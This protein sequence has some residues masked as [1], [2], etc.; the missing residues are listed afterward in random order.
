VFPPPSSLAVEHKYQHVDNLEELAA[1][2]AALMRS[3]IA[4]PDFLGALGQ[5][6]SRSE[7]NRSKLFKLFE[8]LV[9]R[10]ADKNDCVLSGLLRG[11]LSSAKDASTVLRGNSNVTRCTV[12]VLKRPTGL[13]KVVEEWMAASTNAGGGE[14]AGLELVATLKGDVDKM[15]PELKRVVKTVSS[16]CAKS[17][18]LKEAT[19]P[20]VG[21]IVFLRLVCP[22]LMTRAVGTAKVLQ[23]A[24]NNPKGLFL[25][26][27]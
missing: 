12:A 2:R 26:P 17:E 11:E 20:L 15:Q 3:L 13:C 4:N 24:S 22:M 9:L 19:L 14:E 18:L 25:L 23:S 6:L 5:C 10:L 7:T 27:L 1:N 8:E 16:Y 21:G